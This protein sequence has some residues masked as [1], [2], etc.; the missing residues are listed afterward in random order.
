MKDTAYN[1]KAA[2]IRKFKNT[3]IVSVDN[4]QLENGCVLP[5]VDIAFETYGTL[6]KTQDNAILVCHALT[7]SAHVADYKGNNG[8]PVDKQDS[9][10]D[11]LVK[12]AAESTGWWDALI[13][14]GRPLDT[15]R[16]FVICSNILGSCYGTT[17]PTSLNP[18]TGEQYAGNFPDISVRDMVQLQKR[19]LDFLDVQKLELII[20]GSLGGMQ[21]LEWA[22]LYPDCV[23]KIIPIA[24]ATQ[25]SAW[26]ISLNEAARLAIKND[27]QWKNGFYKEQPADGLALARIMA[28][29]SYRSH[30]SYQQRQGRNPA[31]NKKHDVDIFTHTQ[32]E[33]AI[34][35]YLH[36]QGQK[37]VQRFDANSYLSI[38]QAMDR[39][40]LAR[41]RISLNKALGSIKARALCI[42][43]DSDVLYPAFEQRQIAQAIDGAQ[44]AEIK[45]THGHDAFL[46]EFEQIQKM[47]TDFINS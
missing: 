8:Y 17:G 2:I 37:L 42:G 25:H 44:Y 21:V 7:G 10:L 19:L 41:G 31:Q 18:E 3:Q 28:M 5:E 32:P 15:N 36:Y 26:A 6:N 34:Q 39:H 13:G 12:N 45:S 22:V 11:P 4:F 16:Y 1:K 40:D 43:I 14:P 47:V 27:P 24:T 29:I 46:I 33:Y 20:G 30:P 35:S 9:Q 23:R 38:T